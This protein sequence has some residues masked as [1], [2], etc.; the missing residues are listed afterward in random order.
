MHKLHIALSA[1]CTF[2]YAKVQEMQSAK[3]VELIQNEYDR[4]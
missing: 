1:Q 4:I 3:S 2:Q